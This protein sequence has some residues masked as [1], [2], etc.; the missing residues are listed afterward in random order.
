[1]ASKQL[2]SIIAT[3]PSATASG[4]TIVKSNVKHI[5]GDIIKKRTTN[6]IVKIVATA[7][8]D[9]KDELKEFAKSMGVTETVVIL[10]A[11]KDFGLSS[12]D[13]SMLVDKRT[14]R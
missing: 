5:S 9:V 8:R 10:K 7:N 4:E 1:M 14:L 12:I 3:M 13:N 2:E 11:L 6:E